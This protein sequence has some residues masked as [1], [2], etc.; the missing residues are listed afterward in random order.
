MILARHRFRQ[1]ARTV[2]AQG[3]SRGG[4]AHS[5]LKGL[6]AGGSG[7]TVTVNLNKMDKIARTA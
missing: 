6:A 1:I 5:A 4:R 7:G 2:D 3:V